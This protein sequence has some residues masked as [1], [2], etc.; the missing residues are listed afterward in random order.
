MKVLKEQVQK[1]LSDY[2][3][4]SPNGEQFDIEWWS[5]AGEDVCLP[6]AGKTLRELADYAKSVYMLFDP[7]DHAATIYHAK[8]YGSTDERRFY[9][10]ALSG[11]IDLIE[12]ANSIKSFYKDVWNKLE[13]AATKTTSHID[14]VY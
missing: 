10:G 8:H 1:I 12:D 14:T 6:L 9:A 5:P 3:V 4:S 7:D 11:L 2:S 13:A